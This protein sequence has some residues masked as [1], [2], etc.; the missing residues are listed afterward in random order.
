MTT[1]TDDELTRIGRA[2]ELQIDLDRV[3]ISATNPGK[4]LSRGMLR[5]Q[6][7]DA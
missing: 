3:K 4:V 6:N 2:E 7:L 1:W 5:V